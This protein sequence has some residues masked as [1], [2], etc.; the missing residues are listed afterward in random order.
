MVTFASTLSIVCWQQR[1]WLT[2][3]AHCPLS[4][5]SSVHGY[6]CQHIVHCLLAATFMVIIDGG[7]NNTWWHIL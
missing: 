4:V 3:P 2:L 1:S 6:L 5:G 7:V